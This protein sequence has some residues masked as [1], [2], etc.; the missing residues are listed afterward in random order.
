MLS[1]INDYT[2]AFNTRLCLGSF[3]NA[4]IWRLHTQEGL[5]SKKER[6][7]YSITKGRSMC[8]H[9]KHTL[10]TIDLIPVF[11]WIYLRGKCRYCGYT[12]PDNPISELLTPTLFVISYLYWH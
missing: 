9:C 1:L 6:T 3:V 5:K 12:I 8:M 4:L 7:K 11:S 10:S 2:Y